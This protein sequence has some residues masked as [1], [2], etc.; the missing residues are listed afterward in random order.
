MRP[1][2]RD[3]LGVYLAKMA[4]FNTGE[5]AMASGAQ[6]ARLGGRISLA[7]ALEDGDMRPVIAERGR[8]TG[9][10]DEVRT[11]SRSSRIPKQRLSPGCF[12][13]PLL[14]SGTGARPDS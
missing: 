1:A 5:R 9:V 14:S 13:T 7:A 11:A 2:A 8:A 4:L 12:R 10:G 3:S 6:A